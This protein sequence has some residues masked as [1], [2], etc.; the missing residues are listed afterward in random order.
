MRL[1]PAKKHTCMPYALKLTQNRFRRTVR[2]VSFSNMMASGTAM[3]KRVSSNECSC[4]PCSESR[5]RLASGA[6]TGMLEASSWF[7]QSSSCF[8]SDP[9]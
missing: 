2:V 1:E 7:E 8:I 5:P 3:L 9:R 4:M 6:S